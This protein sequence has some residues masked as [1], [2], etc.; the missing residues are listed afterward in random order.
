MANHVMHEHLFSLV[1]QAKKRKKDT[2]EKPTSPAAATPADA[3]AQKKKKKK[4]KS[5]VGE[6]A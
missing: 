5:V 3:D 1:L 4:K 2:A 6:V